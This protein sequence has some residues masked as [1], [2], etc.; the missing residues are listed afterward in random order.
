MKKLLKQLGV[1]LPTVLLVAG[2]AA[3]SCGV[4][5]FCVPAGIITGGCFSMAAGGLLIKR[6][7]PT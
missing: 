1:T 7:R 4:S 2:A 3:V 5:W 6:G